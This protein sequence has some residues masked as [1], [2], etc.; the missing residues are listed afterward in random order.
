MFNS[1]FQNLAKLILPPYFR[2]TRWLSL[3]NAFLS[4][5][6]TYW[7]EF[8]LYR[9]NAFYRI[10]NNASVG[11]ITKVLNDSF[12]LTQR[13]IYIENVNLRD[14]L[15]F[16]SENAQRQIEF[17]TIGNQVVSFSSGGVFDA[18]R[19]DF[20]IYVPNDLNQVDIEN[21]LKAQVDFYKLYA[22]KYEIIY[23]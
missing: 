19:A 23:F 4:P 12:D 21:Q 7:E 6:I 3:I 1:D 11:S 8:L 22:K 15:R 9:S 13:R 10:E 14:A 2:V 18:E 20:Y 16:Y 17:N 5:L